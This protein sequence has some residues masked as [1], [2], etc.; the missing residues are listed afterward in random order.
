M[1]EE[2]LFKAID[3]SALKSWEDFELLLALII[4]NRFLQVY[5]SYLDSEF[6]RKWKTMDEEF[7][8]LKDKGPQKPIKP[9]AKKN[10]QKRQ[11]KKKNL[12]SSE[13]VSQ[14]TCSSENPKWTP[15]RLT[16]P[17]SFKKDMFKLEFSG[18]MSDKS[19]SDNF[20]SDED[21]LSK[22]RLR[23]KASKKIEMEQEGSRQCDN[24]GKFYMYMPQITQM[25][26]KQSE[27]KLKRRVLD[28]CSSESSEDSDWDSEALD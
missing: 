28:D 25:G 27:T 5:Q 21:P 24:S 13:K 16:F 17:L 22:R 11:Q 4:E 23:S 18:M 26:S 6:N 2:L 12:D 7:D 3:E 10:R 15:E 19:T 8:L 20:M 1:D 9:K 14:A